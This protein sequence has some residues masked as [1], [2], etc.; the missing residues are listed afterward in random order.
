MARLTYPLE[1]YR[2]SSYY[3]YRPLSR[4]QMENQYDKMRKRI[5]RN[6]ERIERSEFGSESFYKQ[7]YGRFEAE[8]SGMSERELAFTLQDLAYF[9]ASKRS[10]YSG[11]REIRREAVRSMKRA[12]YDFVTYNNYADFA[13][14]MELVKTAYQEHIYDSKDMVEWFAQH[15]EGIE[16]GELLEDFSAWVSKNEKI[17]RRSKSR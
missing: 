3:S 4:E 13:E 1:Y 15:K 2:V 7:Y 10:S 12:G 17:S 5:L 6:L 8:A 9:R 14:F 11:A 16:P